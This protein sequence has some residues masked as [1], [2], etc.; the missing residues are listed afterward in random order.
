LEITMNN[1]N[2]PTR[3]ATHPLLLAAAVA[4][5]LFC[6]VGVAALMG[7]LPTSS[8]GYN[9]AS[10]AANGSNSSS[11]LA[12]ANVPAEPGY[13]PGP[14]PAPQLSAAPPGAQRYDA[15]VAQT[16]Q[17]MAQ[18]AQPM[19]QAREPEPAPRPAA[20]AVAVCKTCGVIESVHETT[21][22][23]QGTGMGAGAGALLG[24]ILGHQVGGGTG[25]KV[26][27]VAGAVGGAVVGNQ[28]EG[29][30]RA[31]HSYTVTVR[32]NDGSKRTLHRANQPQFHSGDRVRVVNG[33]IRYD[34]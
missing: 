32:M 19:E 22:R 29:N 21:T 28:V 12:A 2:T 7:W 9:A 16:A 14:A 10:I 15:P 20:K 13:T 30:M 25:R 17:P 27:T 23:G 18:A 24:G 33:D 1:T 8:S 6:A 3:H 11:Q 4:V 34:N 26:A 5:V 31:T